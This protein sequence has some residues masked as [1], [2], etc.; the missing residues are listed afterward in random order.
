MVDIDTPNEYPITV[1][2]AGHLDPDSESREKED[3]WVVCGRVG[4]WVSGGFV[5]SREAAHEEEEE[6]EEE[7]RRRKI[8][9][10]RE[11]E[12]KAM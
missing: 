3:G 1:E 10:E 8:R 9:A 4:E 11:R 12:G 5:N 2:Q 6:E 7:E